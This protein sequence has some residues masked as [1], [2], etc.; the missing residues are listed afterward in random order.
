MIKAKC[1][2]VHG[3]VYFLGLFLEGKWSFGFTWY[4]KLRLPIK[5]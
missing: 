3:D 2:H 4:G 1:G 5:A